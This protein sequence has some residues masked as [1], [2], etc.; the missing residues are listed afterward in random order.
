MEPA[1]RAGAAAKRL[2]R[3]HPLVLSGHWLP[4]GNVARAGAASQSEIGYHLHTAPAGPSSASFATLPLLRPFWERAKMLE[5]RL[6]VI[7]A[8]RLTFATYP[9]GKVLVNLDYP[10]ERRRDRT[11]HLQGAQNP[12]RPE[13]AF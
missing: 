9:D 3:R 5:D 7:S 4:R 11:A 13:A 12:R 2:P 8:E 10:S 6:L 1:G